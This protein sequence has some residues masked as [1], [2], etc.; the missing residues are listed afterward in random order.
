M[1]P[2]KI[3]ALIA[4]P[5][6]VALLV[7][8]AEM[9]ASRLGWHHLEWCLSRV[10]TVLFGWTVLPLAVLSVLAAVVAAVTVLLQ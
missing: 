7:L 4:L 9:A 8:F 5:V 2:E 1:T 3:A 6:L 10:T